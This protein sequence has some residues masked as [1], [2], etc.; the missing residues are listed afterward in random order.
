MA[1]H[2]NRHSHGRAELHSTLTD[3]LR[4][5]PTNLFRTAV[6][7]YLLSRTVRQTSP[8]LACLA[9]W[10]NVRGRLCPF[11]PPH[12]YRHGLAFCRLVV[13]ALRPP[14]SQPSLPLL[15]LHASS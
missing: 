13:H 10:A 1:P 12:A 15:R 3:F 6:R 11:S 9:C 5:V 8:P 14:G 7:L 2:V 4:L